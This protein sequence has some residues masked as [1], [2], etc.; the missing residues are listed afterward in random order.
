MI[1]KRAAEALAG[2]Q[3]APLRLDSFLSEKTG[4]SR[5]V[6]ARDTSVFF[7]DGVPVKKKTIVREGHLYR[8][9]Y[10][11]MVAEGVVPQDIPL[12]V[13]YEDKEILV[14]DKPQ[15]L[16]V[17]PALGNWEGTLVNALAW[18]YGLGFLKSMEEDGDCARPGIVQRLD[19]ETSGVMV[20]ALT[21][22]AKAAL[23]EQFAARTVEKRYLALCK[24]VFPSQRETIRTNIGRDPQDRKRFAVREEGRDA[25]TFLTVLRQF[26]AHALVEARIT[27]GRTHQIRVHASYIGHGIV[28]DPLY[29]RP[30][31][32]LPQATLMLHSRRLE[33][34]HPATGE[35]VA[36]EAPVPSRFEEALAVLEGRA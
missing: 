32:L 19:K 7:E 20:V 15:G 27:T 10:I 14:L 33:F 36:F 21:A 2:P 3:E 18:R 22:Q 8:V 4:I 24:G 23:G 31:G 29:G 30:D 12:S 16:V 28:G 1:T 34:D 13:L 9:N 25:E 17:H 11:E 26:P 35:R 5:S 6:L